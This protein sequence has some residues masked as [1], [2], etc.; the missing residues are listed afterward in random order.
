MA[1]RIYRSILLLLGITSVEPCLSYEISTHAR[2]TAAIYDRSSLS[3]EELQDQLGLGNWPAINPF[4][5]GYYDVSGLGIYQ[6][7]A[8]TY[9]TTKNRMPNPEEDAFTVKG[10][11]MRGAIREDDLGW[12]PFT[13]NPLDDEYGNIFRVFHHFYDPVHNRPLDIPGFNTLM[14]QLGGEPRQLA[15]NWA[16]GTTDFQA[17]PPPDKIGRRNHFTIPDAREALYR[18]VTG[19]SS[20]GSLMIY[21]DGN[22]NGIEPP[23]LAAGEQMRKAYWATTFRSLGDVLHLLEDMSQPQHTRNDLDWNPFWNTPRIMQGDNHVAS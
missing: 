6:R 3:Q 15:P 1:N 19:Q 7:K 14:D 11:L 10:W 20:S 8:S 16:L 12:T 22:G 23:S 21:P 4:S 2:I 13:V 9:V 18:A 5:T 17:D